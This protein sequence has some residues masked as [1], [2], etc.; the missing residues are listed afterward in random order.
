MLTQVQI[1]SPP[2]RK[3]VNLLANFTFN[4]AETFNPPEADYYVS[5]LLHRSD[6]EVLFNFL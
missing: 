4:V 2:Q 6:E 5:F 3:N 1:L